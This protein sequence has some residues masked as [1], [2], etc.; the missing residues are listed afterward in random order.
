MNERDPDGQLHLVLRALELKFGVDV[1]PA[2]GLQGDELRAWI[3]RADNA[4]FCCQI[5]GTQSQLTHRPPLHEW[6]RW[7]WGGAPYKFKLSCLH[8]DCE[9]DWF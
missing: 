9:Y 6:E 4:L 5:C 3:G 8:A 1:A 2:A 7:L